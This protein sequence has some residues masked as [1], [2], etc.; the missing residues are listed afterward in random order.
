MSG[1]SLPP[2]MAL[3]AAG[4]LLGGVPAIDSPAVPDLL[5]TVVTNLSIALTIVLLFVFG[6]YA[7]ASLARFA[8]YHSWIYLYLVSLTGVVWGIFRL[9]NGFVPDAVFILMTVAG[10]NLIVHVLRFDRIEIFT[11]KRR[12]QPAAILFDV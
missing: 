6:L 7:Y 2:F 12:E 3:L 9:D 5:S 10:L 4:A 8:P 11:P 1:R